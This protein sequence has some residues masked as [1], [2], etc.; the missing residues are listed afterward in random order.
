LAAGLARAVLEGGSVKLGNVGRPLQVPRRNHDGP[1]RVV[2]V[3]RSGRRVEWARY[4]D[5][6]RAAEMAGRLRA[7]GLA[8]IVEV[9]AT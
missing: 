9:V 8:A 7:R 6:V 1:W 5:I 4:S 2:A 3:E